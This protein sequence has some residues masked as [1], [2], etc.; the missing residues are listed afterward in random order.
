MLLRACEEWEAE[1]RGGGD[2]AARVRD[3]GEAQGADEIQGGIADRG[4]QVAGDP[5]VQPILVVG[6]VADVVQAVLDRPMAPQAGRDGRRARLL[7][8]QAAEPRV[9]LDLLPGRRG[10]RSP[11]AADQAGLSDPGPAVLTLQ[12]AAEVPGLERPQLPPLDPP[13]ALLELD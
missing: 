11:R 12:V 7:R 2:V 10:R 13:V 8:P 6:D 9:R 1:V 3:E 4:E 5:G